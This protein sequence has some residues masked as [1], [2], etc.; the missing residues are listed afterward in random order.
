M[1]YTVSAIMRS[2]KGYSFD[3]INGENA[4]LV[5][6]LYP[7]GGRC[8]RRGEAGSGRRRQCEAGQASAGCPLSNW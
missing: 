5:H 6:F 4:P 8:H 3:L 7:A 2:D 1:A